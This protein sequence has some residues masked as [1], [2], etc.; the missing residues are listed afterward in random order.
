M[1]G[2]VSAASEDAV[3]TTS[4]A[5]SEQHALCLSGAGTRGG[6]IPLV[7]HAKGE[8]PQDRFATLRQQ[9]NSADKREVFEVSKSPPIWSVPVCARNRAMWGKPEQGVHGGLDQNSVNVHRSCRH[10]ESQPMFARP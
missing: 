10:P 4:F 5:T 3:Q 2:C 6:C 8:N 1:G 7:P 9:Y